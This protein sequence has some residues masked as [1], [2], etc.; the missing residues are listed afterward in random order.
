MQLIEITWITA[1]PKMLRLFFRFKRNLLNNICLCAVR[2][3]V[4]FLHTVS[5]RK[6]M[7][8]VVA[9]IRTFGDRINFHPLFTVAFSSQTVSGQ[10]LRKI[11]SYFGLVQKGI[12]Y[13]I[14]NSIINQ[15]IFGL[16]S[17]PA[18]SLPPQPQGGQGTRGSGFQEAHYLY[19]HGA[20]SGNCY[21]IQL[22][23]ESQNQNR[24]LSST[25]FLHVE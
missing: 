12:Y 1:I 14:L 16:S 21:L 8:G 24:A 9:V 5:S 3:L 15:K 22:E 17:R 25:N 2:A 11:V 18:S 23:I 6:L 10:K 7:P 19:S 20:L 4:N 13:I